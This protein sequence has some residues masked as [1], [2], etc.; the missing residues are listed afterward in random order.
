MFKGILVHELVHKFQGTLMYWDEMARLGRFEMIIWVI[1]GTATF[2]DGSMQNSYVR[3]MVARYVR[4]DNIPTLDYLEDDFYAGGW[5]NYV[6]GGTIAEFIVETFGME[7]LVTKNR[8]HGD[9]EGIFGISR[10]EF[11]HQWHQWL[12]ITFT[13]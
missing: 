10:T 13:Q 1:E 6:W 4:S 7:Y 2:L 11:E 9:Y 8:V 12:R 3:G 5:M